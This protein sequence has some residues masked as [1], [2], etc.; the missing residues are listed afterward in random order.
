MKG[1][2]VK[3]ETDTVYGTNGPDYY[4]WYTNSICTN[5]YANGAM[6]RM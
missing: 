5:N 4:R 2:S 6:F 1:N 3:V